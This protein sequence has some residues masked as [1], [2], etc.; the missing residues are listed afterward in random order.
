MAS[1][2]GLEQVH[3]KVLSLLHGVGPQVLMHRWAGQ[4]LPATRP[5]GGLRA[6]TIVAGGRV[7]PSVLALAQD[8]HR[9]EFARVCP[10]A[11]P[12]IVVAGDPRY[13]RIVAS[14]PL[15]QA[16]RRAL[17]VTP[18]QRL[19]FVS[20]TWGP[21]SLLGRHPDLLL[22]LAQELHARDHRIVVALHPS[23]WSW[24]GRRQV[25][26]WHTDCMRLGVQLLPPEEGWGAALV[27]AD[28][29][30]GDYGSV[31]SYGAALGAPVV[32]AAFPDDD[33]LPGSPSAM[34]GGTASR[35]E[36]TR[37]LRAQLDA[38]ARP[39][40]PEQSAVFGARLTSR[41]GESAAILRRIMYGLLDLP[42]PAEP[43]VVER[44]PL[45]EALR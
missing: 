29:V 21:R 38:A 10:E 7:I 34:M 42:E 2:G 30:I 27:A 3:A 16:Y 9:E 33:V 37:P 8:G 35:L 11:L 31:T 36:L 5:A 22:R 4:G 14:L 17:G 19:V 13:D 24:H 6:E 32:L 26:A 25:A 40:C 18:A 28:Q 44:L 15:R 39:L 41:P 45:P 43:A 12:A 1:H 23:T 20:S